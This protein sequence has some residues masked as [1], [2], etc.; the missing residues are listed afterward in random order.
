MRWRTVVTA[1][2]PLALAVGC[3]GGPGSEAGA[4]GDLRADRVAGG[5]TSRFI[6]GPA[7]ATYCPDDS[8]VTVVAVSRDGSVG[9]AVRTRLPLGHARSFAVARSLAESSSAALALRLKSGVARIGASGWIRLEGSAT[10]SGEFDVALPDS[11]G[12]RPRLT[13]RLAGIAVRTGKRAAC[14][15]I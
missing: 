13:G 10:I 1:A 12:T 7:V 6:D 2:L 15:A 14:N 4:N 5:R 8:L 11:A 3:G 9:F